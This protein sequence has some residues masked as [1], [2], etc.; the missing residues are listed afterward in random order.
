M[1]NFFDVNHWLDS[2]NYWLSSSLYDEKER[3]SG[4][5]K[6]KQ[7]L[8]DNDI[9]NAIITSK[10]AL[11]YDWNIGNN[12]LLESNLS[13]NTDNLYYSYILNPDVYFTYDFEEYLKKA[14]ENRVRLFRPFPKRQLF[15]LNDSYMKEIYKILSKR[16][17]PIMFDLKQLDITGAK[18][19][20]IDVL[21]HVLDENENMPVIL[22]ASLKQCMFSRYFFP[23]L[24]R[25]ENLYMEVSGMI[26]YDQIE[27][28][29]EKFGSRRLIFGTNY[30]NLPIEINTNRI[31]LANISQVD[32]E[33]IAFNNL[34]NIIGGIEIG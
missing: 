16:K 30:P 8:K 27:H 28:Y 26:L 24:E 6:I 9:T 2:N 21:E 31:M 4:I 25:F 19:F 22:E 18:Y 7:K 11:N 14:Y 20:D 12:K 34:N 29:V 5:N 10:L 17:F 13:Q 1:I 32:K 15:Y 3:K 33:N 23:L